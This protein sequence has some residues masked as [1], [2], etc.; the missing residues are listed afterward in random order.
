MFHVVGTVCWLIELHLHLHLEES[1]EWH[2]HWFMYEII[3]H[4]EEMEIH[5]Q[6][7]WQKEFCA[8][9]SQKCVLLASLDLCGCVAL[10][11][12]T[13][14]LMFIWFRLPVGRIHAYINDR[15]KCLFKTH[16]IR[17]RLD[18]VERSVYRKLHL[19]G[20]FVGKKQKNSRAQRQRSDG[21]P[22]KKKRHDRAHM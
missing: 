8:I 18:L 9:L 7:N 5:A 1:T 13:I 11:C 10:H 22:S 2:N 19:C 4:C 14:R 17:E 21:T 16:F 3:I 15:I 20:A 12:V 6:T